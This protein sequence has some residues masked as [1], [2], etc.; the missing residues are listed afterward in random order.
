MIVI[1]ASALVD[2]LIN[3]SS[4]P[5]V[6]SALADPSNPILAPH[7]IDLEV[8][9]ALR[10]LVSK[11]EVAPFVASRILAQLA[12][13]PIARISHTYFL[14]RVWALQANMTAYDAV[15]IAIAEAFHASLLTRDR[16]MAGVPGHTA[17]IKV[18]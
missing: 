14:D 4:F 10:R 15:Y 12:N 17:R 3:P 13:L 2:A 7:L 16:K 11:G 9:Q 18:I 1:D 6:E 8:V 5:N